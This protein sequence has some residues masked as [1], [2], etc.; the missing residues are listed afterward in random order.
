[1][2]IL[3][4]CEKNHGKDLDLRRIVER[5]VSEVIPRLLGDGHLGGQEGIQPVV[6]H[7]DL[8]SGNKSKG[9]FVGRDSTN[10]DEPG[11]V[12]DV[13]FDPSAVYGHNEYDMGI[14]NMFGGFGSSFFKEYHS[15]IPKTV[16]EDEYNDRVKLYEAYHHLN[17]HAIF[18]GYKSGAMSLLKGLLKKY[19][20]KEGK[21]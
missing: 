18:S 12:E 20:E 15:I 5:T 4:R 3:D 21:V 16:P 17:H 11:P 1:M 2:M 10:P 8:W 9:S 19:G 7:G 14:M 6:C 13:V